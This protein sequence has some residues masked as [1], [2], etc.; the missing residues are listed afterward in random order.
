VHAVVKSIDVMQKSVV[1]PSGRTPDSSVSLMFPLLQEALAE[2][3]LDVPNSDS[4]RMLSHLSLIARWNRVYNLTAIREPERMLVQHL[5]DSLAVVPELRKRMAVTAPRI[6]DVGSGAGL[7]GLPLA[8][9]WP[10]ARVHLFEPVG[11]KAAFL[12]QAAA[13]LAAGRVE[14]HATR[15][16][17][18]AGQLEP[19]D[20]IICRAFASLAEFVLAIEP[21]LAP[22]T[23]VAAM[24]GQRPDAEIA[25]LPTHWSVRELLPIQ[26]PKLQ[27]QR[28]LVILSGPKPH[29]KAD[30]ARSGAH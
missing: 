10:Q 4:E 14:V 16:Q 19:P 13:E 22:Y 11:K 26:V 7:P 21:L 5:F 6:I 8:L 3:S 23:L 29:T 1:T 12:R 2:L 24:K 27:A 15:V 17:T 25:E 20:L 18:L 30:P 9:I 28:H